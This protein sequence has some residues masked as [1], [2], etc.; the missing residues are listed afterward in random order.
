MFMKTKFFTLCV[1]IF[2]CA[3]QF[4][5]QTQA[6]VTTKTSDAGTA[7]TNI[8]PLSELREGMKGV[9]RTVFRGNE[10]EEF[11]VEILGVVPGAVGPKQDMIVGKISGGQAD[12][13]FFFFLLSGSPVY[14]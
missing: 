2:V 10:P 6:K 11:N 13:T 12:R 14:I 9:A 4:F 7:K 8:F 1:L 5:G 3:A